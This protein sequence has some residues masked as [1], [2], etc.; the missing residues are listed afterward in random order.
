MT[1]EDVR[2][3]KS[4]QD[5]IVQLLASEKFE[6]VLSKLKKKGVNISCKKCSSKGVEGRARAYLSINPVEV[7]L[8]Q[9][10]VKGSVETERLL[11]HELVH[12]YDY[13]FGRCDLETCNGYSND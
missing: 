6:P 2:S 4:C 1:D 9:N 7:V 11:S 13:A 3:S 10:R 8:C 12:A 5:L